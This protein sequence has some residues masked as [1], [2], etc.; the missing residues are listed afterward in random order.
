MITTDPPIV[1]YHVAAMGDWQDVVQEQL[2][3]LARCGLTEIRLTHVGVGADWL[4]DQCRLR[5][6]SATL[7]RTDPNTMHY[8]TFGMFE[9][10]R[11]AR[12]EQPDRAIL[13]MH[14]KGVSAPHIHAKR[15]WRRIMDHHLVERWRENVAMLAEK[16]AVGVNWLPC[17]H[18]HFAGN[19]W[20]VRPDWIR[21][22]TPFAEF[23]NQH[24]RVRF[25]CE[26]WVGSKPGIRPHSL[27]CVGEYWGDDREAHFSHRVPAQCSPPAVT[28]VSAASQGYEPDLCR[29]QASCSRL[30][31]GHRFA[32]HRLDPVERFRHTVKFEVMRKE[33]LRCESNYLFWIDADCEFLQPVSA[34]DLIDPGRPLT[35]IQHFGS[36]DPRTFLPDRLRQRISWPV[37]SISW[38]SCLFG[39]QV[40]A[41]TDQMRRLEWMDREGETY[42][43]H[44]LVMDWSQRPG[45]VHAL[46]CKFAAPSNFAPFPEYESSYRER[47]GGDP[48]ILHHNRNL[49][50]R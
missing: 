4:M 13:Y 28:W 48:V 19:F 29:L 42:D 31:A 36:S 50:R 1:V 22:L 18:D 20:I 8:E 24:G 2:R 7:V 33:L 16:D 17:S 5:G 3:V 40:Q 49:N 26:W 15:M 37:P 38:Q 45:E 44:G 32:F 43:E 23:H 34:W 11:I 30:G 27:I 10:D 41:V 21:K 35:T 39:G 47:A 6:I 14:T 9:V 12:E 46:P 25:T